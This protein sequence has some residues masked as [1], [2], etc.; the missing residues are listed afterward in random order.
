MR[1]WRRKLY[2]DAVRN[3]LRTSDVVEFEEISSIESDTMKF[4]LLTGTCAPLWRIEVFWAWMNG[5][6]SAW[7]KGEVWIGEGACEGF[8]LGAS[9]EHVA[10]ST[11]FCMEELLSGVDG[12]LMAGG[13]GG[14]MLSCLDRRTSFV[15]EPVTCTYANIEEVPSP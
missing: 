11:G 7:T 15:E 14:A 12:E 10:R 13:L 5:K 4:L 8:G 2:P 3:A 6:G 1:I 9:V